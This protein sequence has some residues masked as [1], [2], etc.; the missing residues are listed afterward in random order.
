MFWQGAA[1]RCKVRLERRKEFLDKLIQKGAFRAVAHIRWRN[2]SREPAHES[3]PE[4]V[5]EPAPEPAALPACDG[6][7][8]ASLQVF[9][10]GSWKRLHRRRKGCDPN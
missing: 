9:K 2:G 4:L 1:L 5:P 10:R 3:A 6:S 8:L 7:V